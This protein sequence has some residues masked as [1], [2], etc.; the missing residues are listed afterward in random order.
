MVD[1][2]RYH[3]YNCFYWIFLIESALR[4]TENIKNMPGLI[5]KLPVIPMYYKCICNLKN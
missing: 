2:V 4:C 3:I 1:R 5:E